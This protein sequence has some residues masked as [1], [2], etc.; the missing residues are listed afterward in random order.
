MTME[1]LPGIATG[2]VICI[3]IIAYKIFTRLARNR[4]ATCIDDYTF[5]F[6][7]FAEV[8]RQYPHLTKEQ[9][10][11]VE[12][13]LREFFHICNFGG[14]KMVAMPSQVV[15]VAWHEFILHTRTYADF[16]RRGL[17]RFL[18]HTP[19]EAMR[20]P[21]TAQESIKRAWRLACRRERI[22]PRQPDRLPRLFALDA[23]LTIPDGFRYELNCST[24][25][26]TTAS[27]AA[28]YCGSHI[29]CTSGCGSGCGGGD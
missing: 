22:D 27:G 19:A 21:T 24:V 7:V 11:E 8:S 9:V 17:G 12:R 15:D 1:V 28:T 3:C 20:G 10:A 18:H 16:C 29:G 5:P 13:G 6:A 2:V 23:R 26:G 14:R 25:L 4:R